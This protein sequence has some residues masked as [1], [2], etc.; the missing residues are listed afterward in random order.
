MVRDLSTIVSNLRNH[1]E[2]LS[3]SAEELHSSSVENKKS[4]AEQNDRANQIAT[5]AEE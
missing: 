3:A 2:T 4:I 1:I 5:A